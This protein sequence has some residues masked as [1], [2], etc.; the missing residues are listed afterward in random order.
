[1][2]LIIKKKRGI[3]AG[4]TQR[5]CGE[6]V[7]SDVTVTA[8]SNI[9]TANS[10][11]VNDHIY[12][13]CQPMTLQLQQ[14]YYMTRTPTIHKIMFTIVEVNLAEDTVVTLYYNEV[15]PSTCTLKLGMF[16]FRIRPQRSTQHINCT[17]A[18]F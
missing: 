4:T 8:S 14:R 9:N 3:D 2:Q 17:T 5:Q 15:L 16:H 1:M 13:D 12:S 18:I 11:L 10:S 6:W 7:H